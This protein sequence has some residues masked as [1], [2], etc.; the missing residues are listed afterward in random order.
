TFNSETRYDVK[1]TQFNAANEMI[2]ITPNDVWSIRLGYRYF[3]GG[4][5]FG[6]DS[7]NNTI[8][9]SIY[10]RFNENWGA[11]MTHHFE[12]R[13][14]TLEEQY[15]TI[16]RDFRSWTGAFTL[17]LR[18]NRTTGTDWALAFTFQFKAFPRFKQGMDRDYPNFLLGG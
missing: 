15:Y 3:R 18:D 17:R 2:T 14:G 11:R 1:K 13:D 5:E 7:D 10:Y 8:Y 4:P 9:D 16:Y 6:V 12:A